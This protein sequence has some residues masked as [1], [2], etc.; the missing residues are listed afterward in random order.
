MEQLLTVQSRS[1][2]RLV[3]QVDYAFT[4]IELLVVVAII[5]ILAAMLLPALKNAREAAKSVKCVSNLKQ[6]GIACY[7]YAKDNKDYVVPASLGPSSLNPFNVLLEPYLGGQQFNPAGVFVCPSDPYKRSLCPSYVPGYT[8]RSYNLN[9]RVSRHRVQQTPFGTETASAEFGAIPDLTGQVLAEED[10]DICNT[11]QTDLGAG[12]WP[13]C[14]PLFSA[15]NAHQFGVYRN[16]L[17]C[18]G[19]V[20]KFSYPDWCKQANTEPWVD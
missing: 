4:L 12:W 6:I 18:D 15:G 17:M 14:I 11:A 2:G 8:A 7:L 10:W 9:I 5:A 13:S 3:R 20:R 1:S 19:S 16:A